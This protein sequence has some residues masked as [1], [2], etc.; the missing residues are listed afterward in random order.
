MQA[1][2]EAPSR[3]AT[4]G[5]SEKPEA[6][7]AAKAGEETA[8][9]SKDSASQPEAAAVAKEDE[10]ATSDKRDGKEVETTSNKEGEKPPIARCA[11]LRQYSVCQ[12]APSDVHCRTAWSVNCLDAHADAAPVSSGGSAFATF[13]SASGS[14]FGGLA[15]GAAAAGNG[16]GGFSSTAGG[17]AALGNGSTFGALGNLQRLFFVFLQFLQPDNLIVACQAL[18]ELLSTPPAFAVHALCTSAHY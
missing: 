3:L 8:P 18:L 2:K 16:F 6:T 17:F 10:A 4:G 1:A 7:G 14:G 9:E 11:A 15:S 13:A 12:I 5:A